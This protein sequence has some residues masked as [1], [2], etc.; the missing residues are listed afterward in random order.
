MKRLVSQGLFF[1][2]AITLI[3]CQQ[4]HKYQYKEYAAPG[5]DPAAK[6]SE[7]KSQSQEISAINDSAAYCEAF[8]IFCVSQRSAKRENQFVTPPTTPIPTSFE[9]FND[10]GVEISKGL[11]F[12]NKDSIEASISALAAT[13]DRPFYDSLSPLDETR[14]IS[15]EETGVRAKVDSVSISRLL[16]FFGVKKDEFSTNGNVSYEPKSAPVWVN[17]NGIYLYFNV[18]GGKPSNLRFR[19]QYF[20]DDCY[21]SMKQISL[22]M[23]K[24]TVTHRLQLKQIVGMEIFGNGLTT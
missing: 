11:K 13:Y 18:E 17:R 21:S 8:R 2:A 23:G 10:R 5:Y 9:L 24:R 6:P 12:E 15:Q 3:S 19:V 1:V 22:L 7:N 4:S 14:Q 16:P 20:A